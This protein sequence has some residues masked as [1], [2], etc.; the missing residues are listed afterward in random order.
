MFPPRLIPNNCV[1]SFRTTKIQKRQIDNLAA[2]EGVCQS[3]MIRTLLHESI[4]RHTEDNHYQAIYPAPP[5][6]KELRERN[7]KLDWNKN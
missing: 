3:T 1:L 6:D 2:M 5:T 7:D 4:I